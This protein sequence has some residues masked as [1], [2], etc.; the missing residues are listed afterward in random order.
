MTDTAPTGGRPTEPRLT[1]GLHVG[2]LLQPHPGGIGRYLWELDRALRARGVGVV[3]FAAGPF[4]EPRLARLAD[5]VDLGHP[6][7]PVRYELWHRFGRPRVKLAVDVVHAPSLAVPATRLPLVVTV[8]DIAFAHHPEVSTRR[9]V[10]FHER[11]LRVTRQRA[12]AVVV[13]TAF[14]RDELI[15]RGFDGARVFVAHHGVTVPTP[16]SEVEIDRQIR[17]LGLVAP[18]VLAVG[19][20]EPR[21]NLPVLVA[22]VARARS[23]HPGLE[24]VIAGARGWLDVEGLDRR[25]VHE[26]GAVDETTLDALYRRALVYAMPSRH[27]GFG[28]PLVEA[29]ARG[30]PVL[31]ADVS[32]L[33]E[34]V[35]G[36]G[37]LVPVDDVEA[38]AAAISEIAGDPEARARWSRL[39]QE[40]ATHFMWASSAEIHV[41][42][43][44]AARARHTGGTT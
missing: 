25:F 13:P 10:S 3:P 2:Q 42:A 38:W 16:P 43:Y 33:P 7:A 9:G 26:L 8:N 24:L 44:T 27:E 15:D 17:R 30:C 12:N 34:V 14:V 31:A 35:D 32:A 21:K 22:A 29:M 39:G 18:F 36:G 23:E 28:L 4:P 5:Y 37:E 6:Y 19:T 1:V 20:I 11:A 40:R 41:A